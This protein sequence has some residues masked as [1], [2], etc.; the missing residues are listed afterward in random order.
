[1]NERVSEN[2]QIR[3]VELENVNGGKYY[4]GHEV[5]SQ[6]SVTFVADVGDFIQVASGWG[7]GT[8]LCRVVGRRI[9][10]YSYSIGTRGTG[11][12]ISVYYDQ[13]EVEEVESHWYFKNGWKN[14]NDIEMP[15]T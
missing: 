6:D 12:S 9:S 1:M 8:V 10:S 14:R 15:N 2:N 4:S 7:F 3:E 11:E 5:M 13:Y